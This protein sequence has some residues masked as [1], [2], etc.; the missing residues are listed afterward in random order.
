MQ[1][2]KTP[3][4]FLLFLLTIIA[5]G[6]YLRVADLSQQSYWIDEGYTLNAVL[7]T[8][9]KGYPEL[10]SGW[11]Y[12]GMLLNNYLIA[13]SIK[14]FGFNNFAARLPA[15][16][17]GV[18]LILLIY[19][20]A[21]EIFS[22]VQTGLLASALASFSYWEIAW[23]RQARAY[24]QLQFF[25]FLS[26][27]FLI[28]IFK[29]HQDKKNYF[30]LALVTIA[31]VLSHH[32]GYLLLAI[33]GAIIISLIIKKII[34]LKCANLPLRLNKLFQNKK[35]IIIYFLFFISLAYIVFT[36]IKG[37][38][39]YLFNEN[40]SIAPN[41]AYYMFSEH[42]LIMLLAFLGLILAIYKNVKPIL[43]FILSACYLLPYIIIINDIDLL[44]FR[45]LFFIY[46]ILLIFVAYCFKIFYNKLIKKQSQF[47]FCAYT[48]LIIILL[49]II[50]PLLLN[51]QSSFPNNFILRPA[52]FYSLE[53]LTPQPNF[54][55]AYATIKNSENYQAGKSIVISPYTVL[56][57]IYLNDPGV[58][59]KISLTGKNI[60]GINRYLTEHDNKE[61]Y[62][63]VE[64]IHGFTELLKMSRDNSGENKK[65]FLILD[66][67][68]LGRLGLSFLASSQM[69]FK[70]IY[71]SKQNNYYLNQIWVFEL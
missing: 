51:K 14:I 5:I 17:F 37:N 6:F 63:N 70:Q 35:K 2:S 52:Q 25:F 68:A 60:E 32:Q 22:S 29:N 1:Q 64:T 42:G 12:N 36:K 55:S 41:Y 28:K 18:L 48:V 7:S 45:Y 16:I 30:Y 21:K 44:H 53:T 56:S 38:I 13:T 67:M 8:L 31:C 47:L 69:S 33:Y 15:V 54:Q 10:D 65:N 62:N 43:I 23:S 39:L 27:Y 4:I 19:K 71:Y 66:Q 34:Y 24:I 57:K 20:L 50:S 58:W 40:I 61:F 46:P 11:Q 49:V 9:E 59:L 26:I 3:K